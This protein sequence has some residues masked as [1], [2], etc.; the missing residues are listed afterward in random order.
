MKKQSVEEWEKAAINAITLKMIFAATIG[1]L[2]A[3]AL[4]LILRKSGLGEI[5]PEL[6]FAPWGIA[7]VFGISTSFHKGVMAERNRD[8]SPEPESK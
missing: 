3:T 2:V 1:T 4:A 6:L 7:L 5:K 8:K